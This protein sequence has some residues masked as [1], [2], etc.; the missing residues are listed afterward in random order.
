ML[1]IMHATNM[2]DG[3]IKQLVNRGESKRKEKEMGE[4]YKQ[5]A[6][7]IVYTVCIIKRL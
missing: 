6:K 2:N 5:R 7:S 3:A 1:V 4:D